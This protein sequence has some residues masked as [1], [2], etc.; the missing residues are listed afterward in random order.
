MGVL[1]FVAGLAAGSMHVVLGPDHLA[2]VLPLS[3][4]QGRRGAGIGLSWGLGHAVG[5]VVLVVAG[6]LLRGIVDIGAWSAGA[7]WSVGL[8]L[9]G[10]GLFTLVRASRLTIHQHPHEHDADGEHG[11]VHV[12]V[13]DAT[14]GTTAHRLTPHG[15]DH[16]AFGFGL[17]HGMAGTGHLVGV[18]PT[19]ALA[20][21]DAAAYTAGYLVAAIGAMTG[22]GLLVGQVAAR[23][24]AIRGALSAS[25]V[26]AMVV[27]GVWL[28]TT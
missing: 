9:L 19:V 22:F 11:H 24:G 5:V 25:G 8:L 26:L 16:S 12:H 13:D 3:V 20:P 18:L 27:G 14:V 17:V 1:S 4:G 21:I 2:A 6:Q 7:E 15:H 28:A 10:L 23:P